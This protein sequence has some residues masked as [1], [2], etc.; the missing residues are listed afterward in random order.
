MCTFCTD[1][2]V[3]LGFV[4]D[5]DG[6]Q[7]NEEK[8]HAIQEWLSPTNVSSVHSFH[9]LA[10]FY[11]RFTKDFSSIVAP[12]TKV[13]KKNVGF[14]QGEQQEKAFQLLKEKLAHA[15]LLALPN[16]AKTFEIECDTSGLGIGIVLMQE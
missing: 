10:N 15:P 2:L 9:G 12:I 3:F 8:I 16:F 7:V 4:V 11:R 5:A 6:I 1:R 13:I 14:S